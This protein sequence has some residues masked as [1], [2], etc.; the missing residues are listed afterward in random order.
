MLLVA[1]G[2]S[3]SPALDSSLPLGGESAADARRR[4]RSAWWLN[5]SVG[6]AAGHILFGLIGHGFTGPHQGRPTGTSALAH[7]IGLLTLGLVVVALQRAALR[8]WLQITRARAVL[9]AVAFVL[10]FQLGAYT[11]RPPFDYI[12]GWP[13]LGSAVWI[14]STSSGGSNALW[15]L[16]ATFSFL[17]GLG[18]LVL[19]VDPLL[20]AWGWQYDPR[21]L[22][23]HVFLWF[24][25][26]TVTGLVGGLAS[27]RPL[28]RLLVPNEPATIA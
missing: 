11:L 13:V 24:V 12:F 25:G 18:I 2:G 5:C 22:S 20:A 16:A 27:G 3:L 23:D 7:T 9:A 21:S 26:G 17:L 1:R 28:G 6:F 4:L 15:T 14:G 8:P 10:A 19:A